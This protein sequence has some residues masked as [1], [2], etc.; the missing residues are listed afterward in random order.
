[1]ECSSTLKSNKHLRAMVNL[2]LVCRKNITIRRS[3]EQAM[4][5][6]DAK[7]RLERIEKEREREQR[8]IDRD[9]RRAERKASAAAPV[10]VATPKANAAAATAAAA[11]SAA[12]LSRDFDRAAAVAR[13]RRAKEESDLR[14]AIRR[15]QLPPPPQQQQQQQA[16]PQVQQ[17]PPQTPQVQQASDWQDVQVRCG[18]R[19]PACARCAPALTLA[20]RLVLRHVR[21]VRGAGPRPGAREEGYF[22]N[23]GTRLAGGRGAGHSQESMQQYVE[24]ARP[25]VMVLCLEGIKIID[26]ESNT[27]AMAHALS[28]VCV[29]VCGRG[30]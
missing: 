13:D 19:S 2:T 29:C 27:V 4:F 7:K 21:G 11:P 17:A 23:E 24:S 1:V 5:L 16:P 22:C 30:L 12:Q 8:R 25:A 6:L 26:N 20:G 10:A 3:R 14:E 28:R 18:V 9:Q 15:S